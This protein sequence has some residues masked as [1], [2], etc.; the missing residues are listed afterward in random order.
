VV[1]VITREVKGN[2]YFYLSH[3]YRK[4]NKVLHVE[5]Y[6]GTKEPSP[7]SMKHIKEVFNY[8]VF[9][10]LWKSSVE[11]MKKSFEKQ[12]D[13]MPKPIQAKDLRNFGVRFTQNTNKIEGSQL[14]LR[15]V[16][17]IVDDNVSPKNKPVNDIIE[18]KAHMNVYDEMINSNRIIGWELVFDWHERLFE[19]TKPTIAGL[20]RNYSVEIAGAKFIPPVSGI[21]DLLDELLKWYE[22]NKQVLH[23]VYLACLMHFR[24]VSIHPFGDGNG[25]MCRILMNY[26]LYQ[27]KYPMFDIEFKIRQ[28]Y[29]SAIDKA[30]L[31]ED[32]MKFISWF[33]TRYLKAN[34][35]YIKAS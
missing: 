9:Q 7:E 32:E 33:F 25:R 20:P 10:Q 16:A 23:P 28:S 30:N 12:F 5:K 1:K 3:S 4:G 29:Y 18:A 2:K 21:E 11:Q 8:V 34:E 27:N 6:L 19:L 14:S 17:L 35:K 31:Q 24:F 22:K 13:A 15:D 26:I